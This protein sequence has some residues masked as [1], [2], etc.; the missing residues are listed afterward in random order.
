MKLEKILA[1]GVAED[2]AK[3]IA[4]LSDAELAAEAKKLTD[5]EAELA[6][7]AEKISELTELTKKFDGVDAIRKRQNAEK[8]R[9]NS[10][11]MLITA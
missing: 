5:K 11:I 10:R 8:P 9:E 7:A 6:M 2:V 1:L 3:Q 4:E